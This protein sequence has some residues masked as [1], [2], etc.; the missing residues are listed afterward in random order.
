M[1]WVSFEELIV[2]FKYATRWCSYSS[3]KAS[4]SADLQLLVD[5]I[6]IFLFWEI[7]RFRDLQN[8]KTNKHTVSASQTSSVFRL[9]QRKMT[10]TGVSKLKVKF[11]SSSV[12][13][14]ACLN[15][16]AL[17]QGCWIGISHLTVTQCLTFLPY[18]WFDMEV[19]LKIGVQVTNDGQHGGPVVSTSTSQQ[20]GLLG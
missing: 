8:E 2:C 16:K 19:M 7:R 9:R 17:K 14:F 5:K 3:I 11:N 13:E 1:G 4:L 12:V 6:I 18:H 10:K 15:W 20:E